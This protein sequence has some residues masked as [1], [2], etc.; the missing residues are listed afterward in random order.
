MSPDNFHQNSNNRRESGRPSRWDQYVELLGRKKVPEKARRWYVARVEAFLRQVKPESLLDLSVGEVT[1]FFQELSRSGSLTDWQFRQTIDAI[2]ILLVDLANAPVGG[3]VDW[4]Y[5]REAV[6]DLGPD[7]P[8][9]A[10]DQP[11]GQGFSQTGPKFAPSAEAMP[12]L[13]DL[14]RKI[15]S[16]QYSIRTEQ[17]YIDWCRRFMRFCGD[18][19]VDN[20]GDGDVERFLRYLAVERKVAASTQNLALNALVF[21]FK[22]VVE[23]PLDAMRFSRA[24]RPK[25]LPVVLTREEV[26]RLLGCMDG[27]YGL[28]AG[29][30]YGTGMR[31]MECVRLRIKDADF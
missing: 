7:H 19:S 24:R 21:L 15:R 16:K 30:M 28:M 18:K 17:S 10:R 4:D 5:W 13:K 26:G 31:L 3:K 2:Q 11:I 6:A 22:E 20:L 8:T 27:V 23:R 1:G 25:R 14:A 12:L 9:V 29:L